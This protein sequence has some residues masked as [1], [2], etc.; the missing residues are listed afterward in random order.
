MIRGPSGTRVRLQIL[1]GGL[2]PGSPQKV[3]ELTRDKVKLEEEAAKSKRVEV[4][5]EG[6][7]YRIGV[8]TV[9]SFY[10]DFSARSRGEEDYISTS[11]DVERLIRELEAEG[12]DGIVMDLRQN[13]GGHLS[14]ATE[15]SGLFIEG[16]PVVQLR[17]TRG[18]IEVLD[19][20]SDTSVYDGPLAVLV[21]RFSASASEIFA[22][23]IQD[24]ERGVI[25]GQ[26]TFGKG[27]VQN[28]FNLD[29]VLEGND[30]GQLTLTIGKYYRVTGESTQNRGVL[31]DVELPSSFDLETVGENTRPT[32]LPW[33]R[34]QPTRFHAGRSLDDE[35]LVLQSHQARYAADDPDY[36]YLL[37]E[38][39]VAERER[40]IV[41]VSLNRAEREAEAAALSEAR[42]E[43]ENTRRAALGLD[44][45]ANADE[46]ESAPTTDSI[47]LVQAT[48]MVA[49]MASLESGPQ[50]ELLSTGQTSSTATPPL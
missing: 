41:S 10:Q 36:E 28:L 17:Q 14:E 8:I 12:I 38:F 26:Q 21:D 3:V 7:T 25:I 23:A 24:Y 2:P 37:E 31:P 1:A 48:R 35:V 19:D 46:L 45:L 49:E 47:L 15:L 32:A 16:G 5:F 22:A 20:P 27:S 40:G 13:G 29:R 4:P 50:R 44:P 18:N 43:H 33:D 30:N 6:S 9:P 11:R 34:I 42:L 39:A